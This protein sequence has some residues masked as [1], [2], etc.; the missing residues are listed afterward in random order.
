MARTV[1]R[2]GVALSILALLAGVISLALVSQAQAITFAADMDEVTWK[3]DGSPFACRLEQTIPGFGQ[4]VFERES[5]DSQSFYLRKPAAAFKSGNASLISRAPVWGVNRQEVN[6]GYVPVSASTKP[7]TLNGRLADRLLVELYMG[8]APTFSR[9]SA[10]GDD[11]SIDVVMSSINFRKAYSQYQSCFGKLLPY[12]FKQLAA[13]EIRFESAEVDLNSAAKKRLDQVVQYLQ[14]SS[15]PIALQ[16]DGYADARGR[17]ADN[18]QLA[19]ERAAVIAEYLL[20]KG[21]AGDKIS[22]KNH[23][24]RQKPGK[25][26]MA[27]KA[28]LTLQK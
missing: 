27:S 8:M 5:G 7:V 25:R 15:E 20:D 18:M 22:I 24:E 3:V 26:S 16:I 12:S 13:S 2:N 1:P 4:A 28:T 23:G 9:A 6:L 17:I 14:A 10:V 21:I 19:Q 11:V